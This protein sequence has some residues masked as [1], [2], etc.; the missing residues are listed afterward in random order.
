MKIFKLS[1]KNYRTSADLTNYQTDIERAVSKVKPG[2]QVFVGPNYYYTVPPLG[3][4]ESILVSQE[5]RKN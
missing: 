3:K 1:D 4:R 5:L 2:T